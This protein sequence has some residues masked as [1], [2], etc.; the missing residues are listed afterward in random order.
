MEFL[1]KIPSCC[2]KEELI[3]VAI[4]NTHATGHQQTR[5]KAD[6]LATNFLVSSSLKENIGCSFHS[7]EH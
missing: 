7:I 5:T 6:A 4:Y 3:K 2:S 1:G